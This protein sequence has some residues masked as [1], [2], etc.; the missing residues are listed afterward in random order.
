M[1]EE[2]RSPTTPKPS[3]SDTTTSTRVF[4]AYKALLDHSRRLLEQLVHVEVVRCLS[5]SHLILSARPTASNCYVRIPKL[6]VN[7]EKIRKQCR[8]SVRAV[9]ESIAF[10]PFSASESFKLLRQDPQV[11]CK[12]RE[13]PKAVSE[14]R[15]WVS[16]HFPKL[17]HTFRTMRM[18]HSETLKQHEEDH[19]DAFVQDNQFNG[20]DETEVID[21]KED[22]HD[23]GDCEVA[24]RLM[25]RY[26]S[27]RSAAPGETIVVQSI[28]RTESAYFLL[29]G[30]CQL[31]FQPV[32][33]AHEYKTPSTPAILPSVLTG[34][35][36]VNDRPLIHLRELVAGDCFGLDA[37]AFGFEYLLSTVTAGGARQRNILGLREAALTYVLC[38]PYTVIQQLQSLQHRCRH[39]PPAF[40][41]PF[42]LEAEM[43]LRNTFLFRAMADSSRRFLAAHMHPIVVAQQE[44]LFTPGQPAQVFMIITGQ[45]TL[46]SPR[47]E[48][49]GGQME[50]DLEL[51]L[52]Q[53]HDSVG[54]AEVLRLESSFERYCVVTSA[55][56]ARAYTM[57]STVLLMVLAQE[58][59]SLKL[60]HE[61]IKQRKSWFELRRATALA[62]R[63]KFTAEDSE[64]VARL[65]LAA[66]R[67]KGRNYAKVAEQRGN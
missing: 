1:S 66:Q 43:F 38:L 8:N 17:V 30:C 12:R 28:T 34:E 39:L 15:K 67:R 14:F 64:H 42:S 4:L 20:F 44:Y 31:S 54:L 23:A 50:A 16:Q 36:G 29:N 47:E 62:Q 45:L 57:P 6:F 35:V 22:E 27:V 32:I 46:G 63:K 2:V 21:M 18:L 40:P 7:V 41:Y 19:T 61:W 37:A 51:E 33:L 55:N 26:A 10:D 65:T 48:R 25:F 59:A 9:L 58:A 53:A 11:A 56:G 49:S 60:I 5:P 24:W 3:A 52:L 13:D